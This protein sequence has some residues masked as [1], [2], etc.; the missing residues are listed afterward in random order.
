MYAMKLE[1]LKTYNGLW[2][3]DVQRGIFNGFCLIYGFR[4]NLV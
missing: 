1:K 4:V 2:A 3:T